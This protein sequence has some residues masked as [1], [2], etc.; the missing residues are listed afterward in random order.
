MKRRIVLFDLD[1][2]ITDS[3]PII[4]QTVQDSLAELG[5]EP[6]TQSELMRWV[7]P[8]LF[9]SFRDFAGVP[10]DRIDEALLTYRRRYREFMFDA[11]LFPGIAECLKN[12]DELGFPLAVATSKT[13]VLSQP[14]VAKSAVG[15]YF[16]HVAGSLDDSSPHS[17]ANVIADAL[18]RMEA[19][20]FSREGA[21]M[22]GD[23]IFDVEGAHANGLD[24]IGV[25]WS[26]TDP[27][28]FETATATAATPAELTELI[29]AL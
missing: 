25:L 20:G 19:D 4:T 1:G 2:T 24:V 11:P 10:A 17:K 26:G 9:E 23:R 13:Q 16:Q 21:I 27:A 8:P 12:L 6:Q 3:A 7:G 14:S 15:K 22:V 28:E 29:Q 18:Q 5:C